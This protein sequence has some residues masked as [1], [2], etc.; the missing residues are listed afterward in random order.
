M[1][2]I[3][4]EYEISDETGIESVWATKIKED[5]YRIENIPFYVREFAYGDLVKAYLKNDSL[6]VEGL[7]EESGNSTIR[8]LVNEEDLDLKDEITEDLIRLGC[9][10][11]G[12]NMKRLISVNIPRAID[13]SEVESFL[14]TGEELLET[15]EYEEGCVSSKHKN[16]LA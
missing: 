3:F 13:Y 10:W 4:F 7:F 16:D 8:I 6:H 2:K 9:G 5:I 12:S 14:I 1:Y 15:F 11:E